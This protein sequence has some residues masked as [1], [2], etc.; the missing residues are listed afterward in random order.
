M[1]NKQLV[2][3]MILVRELSDIKQRL[4]GG[5]PQIILTDVTHPYVIDRDMNP[6]SLRELS[7]L[8]QMINSTE[9]SKFKEVGFDMVYEMLEHSFIEL[10]N[11]VY[12]VDEKVFAQLIT[13]LSLW[14]MVTSGTNPIF[15][16]VIKDMI[17]VNMSISTINRDNRTIFGFLF[18][19]LFHRSDLEDLIY[20]MENRSRYI[21]YILNPDSYTL[22]NLIATENKLDVQA[23]VINA[24]EK[25]MLFGFSI[26]DAVNMRLK[27]SDEKILQMYTGGFVTIGGKNL[28]EAA[29]I[30]VERMTSGDFKI[31]PLKYSKPDFKVI[32][33]LLK[34]NQVDMSKNIILKNIAKFKEG[35]RTHNIQYTVIGDELHI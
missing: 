10:D 23:K 9:P 15:T 3:K 33:E 17:I 1:N 24:H 25:P 30:G 22:V 29:I 8:E 16:L 12:K 18:D 6:D 5:G 20:H 27:L 21:R 28:T 32:I 7:H 31:T 13:K 34:V 11:D 2:P 14:S 4:L 35:L 26:L 19:N